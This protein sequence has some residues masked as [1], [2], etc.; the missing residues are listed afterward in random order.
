MT[1]TSKIQNTLY[2]HNKSKYNNKKITQEKKNIKVDAYI[3]V[4]RVLQVVQV[5][6]TVFIKISDAFGKIV[7]SSAYTVNWLFCIE[8]R[9]KTRALWDCTT[10]IIKP[11][12]HSIHSAK[13]HC[14]INKL[15][16]RYSL[17]R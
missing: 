17:D 13:L 4:Q 6:I 1:K 7:V 5:P 11:Q 14:Q 15:Q 12:N 8:N 3:Y 16:A 9:S 10:D 2:K